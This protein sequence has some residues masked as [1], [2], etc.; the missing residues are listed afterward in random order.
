MGIECN[1]NYPDNNGF[2]GLSIPSARLN[3]E[4]KNIPHALRDMYPGIDKHP[5]VFKERKDFI[6]VCVSSDDIK[7]NASALSRRIAEAV[8]FHSDR[9][10]EA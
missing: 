4:I 10:N 6:T 9:Y 8:R 1:L 3:V 2:A 5:D 7:N